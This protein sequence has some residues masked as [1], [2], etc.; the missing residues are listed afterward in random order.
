VT[1]SPEMHEVAADESGR[2]GDEHS[3]HGQIC[4]RSSF[5]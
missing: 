4:L 5:P 3:T 2:S 1:V